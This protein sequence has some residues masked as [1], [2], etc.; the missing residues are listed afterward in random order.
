MT[1]CVTYMWMMVGQ[2]SRQLSQG[3]QRPEA[4]AFR[5]RNPLIADHL[6]GFV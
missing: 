2:L 3:W 5:T 4:G 6:S 1:F